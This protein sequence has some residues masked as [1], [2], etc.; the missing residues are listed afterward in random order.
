MVRV[1]MMEVADVVV[2]KQEA[3]VAVVQWSVRRKMVVIV[4]VCSV[5][6]VVFSPSDCLQLCCVWCMS[7]ACR[8][9]PGAVLEHCPTGS[10]SLARA[11]L[12][13]V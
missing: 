12:R 7:W 3:V 9:S 10:R 13:G 5:W 11:A 4:V 2:E 8:Y 6:C 1:E